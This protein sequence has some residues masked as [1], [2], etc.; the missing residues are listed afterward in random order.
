M[1]RAVLPQVNDVHFD[2]MMPP[3]ERHVLVHRSSHS[4]GLPSY[5]KPDHSHN[6][7]LHA[8]GMGELADNS[9]DFI[10]ALHR[11]C[12]AP[13]CQTHAKALLKVRHSC[14]ANRQVAWDAATSAAATA[15]ATVVSSRRQKAIQVLGLLRTIRGVWT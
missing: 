9:I 7:R 13:L 4:P 10:R 11:T 14:S 15:A 8:R 12:V 2:V 3:R 5:G 1:L 6:L